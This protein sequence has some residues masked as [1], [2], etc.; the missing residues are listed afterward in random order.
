VDVEFTLN[1]LEESAHRINLVQCRPFKV[2]G[3][4]SVVDPPETIDDQNLVI[5]TNGPVIGPV[6]RYFIDR[7]IYVVPSVYA[8]MPERDRYSVAKLV[9]RLAHLDETDRNI[10][11]IGPG[12]WGT[13]TPSLGVPV[14]FADISP[15]AVVC[16]IAEMHADLIPEVSLGTH[17]FNE[18]VENDMLYLAVF[19]DNEEVSFNRKFLD[20][21]PNRLKNI[22]PDYG[23][24]QEAVRVIEPN[25]I[26]E[27]LKLCINANA[28]KQRAVCYLTAED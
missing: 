16:E 9:G 10:M 22:L 24:W 25:A 18:I 8:H 4:G 17:F 12:R 2:K 15:A 26:R 21:A 3:G 1:F 23:H 7:L 27:N 6:C 20:D 14:S 5:Q 28:Q 19:P 11:L 13:M